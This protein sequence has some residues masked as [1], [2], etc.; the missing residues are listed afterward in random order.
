MAKAA[1]GRAIAI[2]GPMS[3]QVKRIESTP[4]SGVVVRKE[5]LAGSLAFLRRSS[6][7]IGT[8]PQLQIGNGTP[9]SAAFTTP[10]SPGRPS[11]RSIQ[12]EGMSTWMKPAMSKPSRR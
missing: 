1:I 12:R 2:T 11:Q 3:P 8:T 4:D 7:A 6:T 9:T 5:R 10:E